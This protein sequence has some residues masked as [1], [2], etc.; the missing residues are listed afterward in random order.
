MNTIEKLKKKSFLVYGLGLTGKSVINFFKKNNIKNFLVWDDRIKNLYKKKRPIFL[1]KTLKKVDYIILSPG[2]NL[3][4]S[5]Y[6][7]KLF[8]YKHKIITDLDLIFLL[9]RYFKS[10]VVTGTNGKSTTCKI[11]SHVLKKNKFKVL[12]GGNIGTPLL[13]LSIRKNTFL[14]IEASSFQLAYSKFV[15]PDY[16]MLLNI[17]NDHLDWHGSK[18]NYI[19][20]KF[21]IFK[22][23]KKNQYSFLN[24]KF[25]LKFKKKNLSGKLIIPKFEDYLKLKNKVKNL[26]LNSN[27]NDENMSYTLAFSK[28][29][30]IPENLFLNSLKSFEGLPHRYEVFLEKK[31]CV[32][33]NDSKATTFEASKM[34]LASTKNIYWIVGGLPKKNDNINLTNLNKNIV[35]CYLIGKHTNF[36][37]NQLKNKVNYKISK[38]I[39]NSLIHILK[40][41]KLSKRENNNIL[42]SPA[43][44]SFDQFLNFEKRGNE[45]KRLSK[46]YANKHI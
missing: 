1:N 31:N 45:F 26:Y 28:V 37:K 12:L 20:S 8:K 11:I 23:Q 10:I 19:N 35:K 2:I 6:K 4:K 7:K 27:I 16:A 29:L 39:K 34:A 5:K 9:K 22:N 25:K 40:D 24:E 17:T 18:K 32:F 15:C 42:L 44:A 30:R 41:I 38:N 14:I 13:N 36:F 3:N 21:K 43:A 46:H 33:I